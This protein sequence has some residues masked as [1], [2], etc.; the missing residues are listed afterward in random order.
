MINKLIIT[1]KSKKELAKDQ[2]SLIECFLK[3]QQKNQ[4][5]D[6]KKSTKKQ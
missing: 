5:S 4:I 6:Q 2:K 3:I 1:K